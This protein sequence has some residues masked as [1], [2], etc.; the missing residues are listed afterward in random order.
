MI[1]E[2]INECIQMTDEIM[3]SHYRGNHNVLKKHIHEDCLWIGSVASEFYHGRDKILDVLKEEDKELPSIT[4][5]SKEYECISHDRN[6][7][8]IVGI[9]FGHTEQNNEE[10]FRDMQRVTFVWKEEEGELYIKHIHVSNPMTVVQDNEIFPHKLGVF[11]KEYVNMMLHKELKS[12][13]IKIKDRM[14]VHHMIQLSNIFYLEAFDHQTVIHTAEG[15]ILTRMLLSDVEDKIKEINS[16][17]TMRVHKSYV[18]NR[19][20]IDSIQR[21]E[22]KVA[23]KYRIPV[24]KLRYQE[25]QQKLHECR[26]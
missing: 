19:Y 3:T 12:E 26:K 25:V 8:V 23:G 9:Y 15:D 14:N 10:L 7:C 11:A 24:S 16:D 2:K 4:L 5:N 17:M 20:Y 21:Y 18:V 6:S 22:M 13:V 1:K